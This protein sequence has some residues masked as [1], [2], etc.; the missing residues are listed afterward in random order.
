MPSI[1][2]A[3]WGLF[4]TSVLQLTQQ[5]LPAY[6]PG[7]DLLA[8]AQHAFFNTAPAPASSLWASSSSSPPATVLDGAGKAWSWRN[9]G[10]PEDLVEVHTIEVS[11]DPPQRGKNMTIHATGKVQKRIEEGAY[12][13]VDV[14]IGYIRLLHRQVDICEEARRNDAEVK[15]PID[16]DEYDITQTVQLPSQI[17]PAKF[18]VHVGAFSVD[19]EP[20]LCLDLSVDF[21]HR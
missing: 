6:P 11:P 9:C 15:C 8:A 21:L 5:P 20:L 17:P 19:D 4:A 10:D 3:V 1:V 13:E 7:Q 16:P 18:G 2:K 12:A 14:K